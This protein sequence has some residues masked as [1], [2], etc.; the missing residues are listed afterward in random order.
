[1]CPL[2][3]LPVKKLRIGLPYVGQWAVDRQPQWDNKMA[4]EMEI[5]GQIKIEVS[6]KF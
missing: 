3:Y 6:K 5:K 2:I 1:M 4:T